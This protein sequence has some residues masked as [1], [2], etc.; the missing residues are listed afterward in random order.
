MQERSEEKPSDKASASSSPVIYRAKSVSAQPFVEK[1]QTGDRAL[2][3]FQEK[4]LNALK[5]Q[6]FPT[7]QAE[8]WRKSDPESLLS[9]FR[10]ALPAPEIL[11]SLRLA[12][13]SRPEQE[14]L[15]AQTDPLP[16][17]GRVLN[18]IDGYFEASLSDALP[19]NVTFESVYQGLAS[20]HPL[21]ELAGSVATPFE[22]SFTHL[23]AAFLQDGALLSVKRNTK[24]E[25]P[26]IIRHTGAKAEN[27]NF[28]RNIIR[29]EPGAEATIIEIFNDANGQASN[30]VT[31][32]FVGENARVKRL[33]LTL[34]STQ[35]ARY[36]AFTAKLERNAR[37]ETVA[38]TLGGYLSRREVFIDL[39]GD[40]AEAK[41]GLSAHVKQKR[42]SDLLAVVTHNAENCV[43]EQNVRNLADAGG[44]VLTKS[45]TIVPKTGQKADGKQMLRTLLLSDD[46]HAFA[47][48]ELEIYADD[49]KCAHGSTVGKPDE[50]A[51]Y[52]MRSR[53]IP[54]AEAR[55][56]LVKAFL[57]ET[58]EDGVFP[59]SVTRYLRGRL[60][61]D[62]LK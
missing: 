44:S 32:I 9:A 1:A 45:K 43:S 46:A 25:E 61:E 28:T 24:T 7:K 33:H 5:K 50:A 62:L 59:E 11:N 16:A 35:S 21:L 53:G 10:K 55:I 17:E 54:E 23:N 18:F 37:L 26:I 3:P 48:P 27:G 8:V 14:N 41:Y 31:E 6:G 52:Y 60:R 19:E 20:N 13:P 36:D 42:G 2:A 56:L 30:A 38:F 4:A 58:L 34:D 51:L 47:K 15:P 12:P 57:F 29:I 49:V 39:A 22:Q 40:R